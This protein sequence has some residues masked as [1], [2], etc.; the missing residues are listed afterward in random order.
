MEA[1]LQNEV[2]EFNVVARNNGQ[3]LISEPDWCK[4]GREFT[5]AGIRYCAVNDRITACT[6][7]FNSCSNQEGGCCT[8]S[9][10][11]SLG[12][13][14]CFYDDDCG[15]NLEC[16]EDNCRGSR[17]SG[18]FNWQSNGDNGVL[19]FFFG[20]NSFDCCVVKNTTI[21][22]QPVEPSP[23]NYR[24][25]DENCECND[26]DIAQYIDSLNNGEEICQTPDD[27]SCIIDPSLVIFTVP[28]G[29]ICGDELDPKSIDSM[30]G[31]IFDSDDNVNAVQVAEAQRDINGA[32][33]C[34]YYSALVNSFSLEAGYDCVGED[35]S[36]TTCTALS[37]DN[38]FGD[39][40]DEC[41]QACI[42]RSVSIFEVKE[43]EEF[44]VKINGNFDYR[45]PTSL[46]FGSDARLGFD[47]QGL[48]TG[49]TFGYFNPFDPAIAA[50]DE[51]A[52]E[53]TVEVFEEFMDCAVSYSNLKKVYVKVFLIA[54]STYTSS[55]SSDGSSG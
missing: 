20:I 34:L 26:E 50:T 51:T 5:Q 53:F 52:A 44:N 1:C 24:C 21:V 14:N 45:V 3:A 33:I 31:N 48:T 47:S 9:N 37:C 54:T 42:G 18:K 46:P 25:G 10:P 43:K 2:A 22:P 28:T 12:E 35:G 13:G 36:I 29:D 17:S 11:C 4:S 40:K 55:L 32:F 27:T 6:P 49:L 16:G 39:Q 41:E 7:A 8:S 23:G 15:D 38:L 30:D 19:F